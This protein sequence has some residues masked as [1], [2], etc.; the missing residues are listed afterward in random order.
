LKKYIELIQ[1]KG[2]DKDFSLE[3]AKTPEADQLIEHI[4][5][6]CSS[7]LKRGQIIAGL[8]EGGFRLK[9]HDKRMTLDASD[10]ALAELLGQFLRKEWRTRL[11][12]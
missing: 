1:A 8:H 9:L 5:S 2:W 4:L 12:M 3:I 11:F 10:S 6:E 7:K